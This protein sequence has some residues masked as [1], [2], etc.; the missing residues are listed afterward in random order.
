MANSPTYTPIKDKDAK[1]DIIEHINRDHTEE[2]MAIVAHYYP[3]IKMTH[4]FI[5]DIYEEGMSVSIHSQGRDQSPTD[6]EEIFI[7]F[8]LEGDIEEQVLY[9]AYLAMAKQ[10]KDL[11]GNKKQYFEVIGKH[12]I[13]KNMTR[14]TLHSQTPLPENYAGYAY[15][16]TL[17]VLNKAPEKQ[18]SDRPTAK[19]IKLAKKYGNQAFL[20][21]LKQLSSKR[22][23]QIVETMNKDVRIYTLRKAWKSAGSTFINQGYMDIF[24]HDGSAGSNWTQSLNIGDI[25]FSRTEADDKHEHLHTGQCVLIADETAYP[26][27]A[28]ILDNWDNPIAPH[29][30]ILSHAQSEQAYFVAGLEDLDSLEGVDNSKATHGNDDNDKIINKLPKGAHVHRIVGH[31]SEQGTKT[32]EILKNIENIEA[33]WGALENNAAKIVRHYLRNERELSGKQNHIK[34]YWRADKD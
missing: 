4:A 30:I 28:G 20:W 3:H 19:P 12:K 6:S 14:L 34:G 21:L 11:T 25:I 23:Y 15:G 32:I 10:G 2:I 26:A 7:N 17:K 8:E 27:L 1:L 13:T 29:I 5:K 22:R 24:T 18:T 9:L 31:Y 16:M 33:S